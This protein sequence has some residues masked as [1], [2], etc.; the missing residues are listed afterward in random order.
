MARDRGCPRVL[1]RPIRAARALRNERCDKLW[2]PRARQVKRAL[3]SGDVRNRAVGERQA[4]VQALG[5]YIK[6]EIGK[7]AKVVKDAHVHVD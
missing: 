2:S 5:R 4:R 3:R 7:W 1:H 6:S